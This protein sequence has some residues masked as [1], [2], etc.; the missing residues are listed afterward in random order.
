MRA[1]PDGIV[2]LDGATG[3]ELD[4]KGVDCSR[5]LWSC[6]ANLKAPEVL[7][8][9]HKEYLL[10]GAK[11]ITTNTFR[12]HE[13]T[14]KKVGLGHLAK[15]LTQTAVEM[16][17]AARD[18]V[19]PDALV[20]GSVAPVENCYKAELAPDFAYCKQEYRKI[21]VNLLEAGV[22]FI[23]IETC[24]QGLEATAAAEVAQE[25]APGH[26]GIAFSVPTETV[27]ILRCGT[28]LKDIIHHFKD[29]AFI[30]VNCMDGKTITPQVKHL[31]S[32]APEGMR[33]AAYGNIGVWTVT[34]KDYEAGAN[35]TK[36]NDVEHDAIYVRCVKEW[37]EAGASIVGGCCGTTPHS[38][39]MLYGVV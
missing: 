17:C 19:N 11:A 15:Q 31:K 30:G 21:I 1:L 9:V 7:K 26:W 14:L 29:A 8:Q 13:H 25:L 27:G 38:I 22:D 16:A 18:E 24:A 20:L 34:A 28:P 37:I 39:R 23:L 36:N 4:R 6:N 33:I 35:R 2:V 3:S 32:I 5:P 12:T 10:N